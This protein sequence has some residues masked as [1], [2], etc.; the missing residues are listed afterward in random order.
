[1]NPY[2]FHAKTNEA[3]ILKIDTEIHHANLKTIC[4]EIDSKQININQIDTTT[5]KLFSTVLYAENFEIFKLNKSKLNI[6]LN[7]TYLYKTLKTLKIKD[8]LE[9]IVQ[10]NNP[11]E[12]IIQISPND[13]MSRISRTSIPIQD[14]EI[15]DPQPICGYSNYITINSADFQ[16]VLK[17]TLN[18]GKKVV[19]ESN[20]KLI[21]F[22]CGTAGITKREVEFGE[23]GNQDKMM[24]R[25]EF[26]SVDLTKIL[27]ITGLSSTFKIYTCDNLPLFLHTNVGNLGTKS[28]YIKSKKDKEQV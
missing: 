13:N 25:D 19:I 10:E 26:D 1:M 3:V 22:S 14:M 17:D 21:R 15:I 24:Y 6:G 11:T 18:L 23:I 20:E 4:L 2:I 9:F 12:L 27:K 5:N 8:V 28:I 16:K 7:L